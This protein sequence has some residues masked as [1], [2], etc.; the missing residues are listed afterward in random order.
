M[1]Q[2]LFYITVVL[3]N[4]STPVQNMGCLNPPGFY[5]NTC[6]Y[7]NNDGGEPIAYFHLYNDRA[8]M[9]LDIVPDDN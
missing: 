4:L 8:W 2:Q 1:L 7:T 9:A 3:L 6:W 5:Q